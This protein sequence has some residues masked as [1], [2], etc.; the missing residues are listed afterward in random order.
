MSM[1]QIEGEKGHRAKDSEKQK[2]SETD[3]ELEKKTIQKN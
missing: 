1:K 3:N 2:K